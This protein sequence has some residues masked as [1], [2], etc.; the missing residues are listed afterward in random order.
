MRHSFGEVVYRTL[1][2]NVHIEEEPWAV[3]RVKRVMDRLLGDRASEFVVVIPW[4]DLVTA[5][6][7]P[8]RYIFFARRLY[9]RCS[10]DEEVALILAHEIAHHVLVCL[11]L[12]NTG[13][14][15]WPAPS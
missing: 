3:D 15:K 12:G 14:R 7:T 5:F 8:G 1:R 2:R 4:I 9:E 10:T 11:I 13:C 6:T